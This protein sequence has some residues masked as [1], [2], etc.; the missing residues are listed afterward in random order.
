MRK[1][2]EGEVL[3]YGP[4]IQTITAEGVILNYKNINFL[5]AKN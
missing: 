5:L 4:N 2:K 3:I 1:Y